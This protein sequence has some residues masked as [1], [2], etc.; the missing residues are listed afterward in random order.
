MVVPILYFTTPVRF[1]VN[2][3]FS[4]LFRKNY[5]SNYM[6]LRNLEASPSSPEISIEAT[7]P[8]FPLS[9]LGSNL[10]Y[11]WTFYNGTGRINWSG[12]T[13]EP[14]NVI[15]QN[16]L[17]GLDTNLAFSFSSEEW[18]FSAAYLGYAIPTAI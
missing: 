12:K 3:F 18:S 11:E 2:S 1:Q 10:Y 14:L 7:N 13:L 4:G 16:S 8:N 17:E 15:I 6:M 9:V 5:L